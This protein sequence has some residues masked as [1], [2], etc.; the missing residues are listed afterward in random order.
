MP[1]AKEGVKGHL[2]GG[3]TQ[4]LLRRSTSVATLDS[5]RHGGGRGAD[6]EGASLQVVKKRRRG[7]LAP[8]KRPLRLPVSVKD[9]DL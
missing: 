8:K 4:K 3:S 5:E 1:S 6:F 9:L 2:L 7:G